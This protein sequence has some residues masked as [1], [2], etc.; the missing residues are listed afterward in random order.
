MSGDDASRERIA[1]MRPE[2]QADLY[3]AVATEFSGTGASKS[4]FLHN[5][6]ALNAFNLAMRPVTREY[7]AAVAACANP[8]IRDANRRW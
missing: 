5:M 2:Q 3:D 6:A 1:A 7:D 4:V 8:A